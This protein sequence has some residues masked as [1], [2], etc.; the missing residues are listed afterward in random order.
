MGEGRVKND[1][2]KFANATLSQWNS[3]SNKVPAAKIKC[4]I[5]FIR[6]IQGLL[7]ETAEE[8]HPDGAD[9]LLPMTIY[10]II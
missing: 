3:S 8:G 4:M 10:T 2:L 1:V 6:I 9:T 5:N 7:N